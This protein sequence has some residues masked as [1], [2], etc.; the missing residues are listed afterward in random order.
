MT[1]IGGSWDPASTSA[2]A[3]IFG[4]LSGAL[5][6]SVSTWITQRHEDRRDLL[7][8]RISYREQLYSDSISETAQALADAIQP[9]LLDPNKLTPTCAHF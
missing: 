4:S 6:P 2:L 9:N 8:E 5:A 3:A 1:L 7:A